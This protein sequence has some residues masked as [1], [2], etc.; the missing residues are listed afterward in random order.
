M[1]TKKKE[2]KV[3]KDVQAFTDRLDI[4]E[5]IQ[6]DIKKYSGGDKLRETRLI[7]EFAD[8]QTY[9]SNHGDNLQ[10][11]TDNVLQE[12]R[13]RVG[14]LGYKGLY[15]EMLPFVEV[16]G[17]T[18]DKAALNAI[19]F[20]DM[21]RGIVKTPVLS[22]RGRTEDIKRNIQLQGQEEVLEYM[23]NLT[24]YDAIQNTLNYFYELKYNYASAAYQATIYL[25]QYEWLKKAEE[26]FN[27]FTAIVPEDKQADLKIIAK[28]YNNYLKSCQPFGELDEVKGKGWKDKDT[29]NCLDYAKS[30]I[31]VVVQKKLANVKGFIEGVNKWVKSFG[32][33]MFIPMELRDQIEFI[34]GGYVDELQDKYYTSHLK[35]MKERGEI[36]TNESKVIAV[37]PSYEDIKPDKEVVKLTI[38]K[39]NENKKDFKPRKRK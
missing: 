6:K 30:I 10:E 7:I 26:L 20:H 22:S 29:A 17:T 16:Y 24:Y 1:S 11:I 28:N 25:N 21:S 23:E 31:E 39:L 27:S 37:F 3:D 14:K 13:D 2:S 33:E 18:K 34:K 15:E 9:Y 35:R 36:I 32:A 12:F 5:Q 19:A 8:G 4:W 38:N